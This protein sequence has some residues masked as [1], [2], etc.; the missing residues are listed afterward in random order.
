MPGALGRRSRGRWV[1]QAADRSGEPSPL[2]SPFIIE[3]EMEAFPG[4]IIWGC[5]FFPAMGEYTKERI[6]GEA[7][8]PVRP[9]RMVVGG[10]V[11]S[12][13]GRGRAWTGPILSNLIIITGKKML[14]LP[15][16]KGD[17]I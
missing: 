6:G 16:E 7:L 2:Q 15:L 5:I 9:Q 8:V 12:E 17:S 14:S 4:L 1:S 13:D 10:G 3:L 11:F